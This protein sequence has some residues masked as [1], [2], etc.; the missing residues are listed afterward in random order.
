MQK[1]DFLLKTELF[2]GENRVDEIGGIINKYSFKKICVLIGMSSVKRSGLLDKVLS[3]LNQHNFEYIVLEGIRP[4]PDISFVYDN[5]GKIK[6]F[7]PDLLLAI[8]GGS[9]ID[10]AKLISH[11]YYYGGDAFDFNLHKATPTKVLPLGVILTIS[12]AGSEMSTSCVMQDDKTKTKAGFNSELNRPL[13]AICD[14]LLT[15]SVS[16]IQTAYGIVDI[17][18][19]TLERY[20]N[21]SD[22]YD[23]SDG[24][25]EGLI[26]TVL[27]AGLVAYNNPNDISS[28]KALMLASS[29]SHNGVTSIGKSYTMYVHQLEHVLSGVYKDVAHAAGLAVLWPKWAR[30]YLEYD[31]DKFDL[32]AKNVFHSF[33]DD[34]LQNGLY[35]I[36]CLENYFKQLNM[37]KTYKDLGINDVDINYLADKF[38]NNGTRVVAHNKKPLDRNVAYEIFKACI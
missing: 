16:K 2:F 13:F 14:P 12:A 18:M 7:E 20:F 5:L 23:L 15:T 8:G 17:L 10:T 31:V 30:F 21:P 29:F 1:F 6:S 35:A 9:V 34:K 24:F 11:A 38:S 27:N 33:K 25:S 26:R 36:E 3:I 37:P 19:H 4:N 28:R 32:L 22:K